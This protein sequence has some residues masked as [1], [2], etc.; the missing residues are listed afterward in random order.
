MDGGQVQATRA[1]EIS[2]SVSPRERRTAQPPHFFFFFVFDPPDR[3]PFH[4][5]PIEK[6]HHHRPT[7]LKQTNKAFKSKHASKGLLKD[8]SKGKVNRVAPKNQVPKGRTTKADR[9]NAAKLL[10]QKKREELV[11]S[12]RLFEGRHGAPKIVAVV[13]LCPDVDAEAAISHLYS[14]IGEDL[15]TRAGLSVL[16]ADR[17]KQKIQFVPLRRNFIDVIDAFKVAD[18]AILLMSA[19]VEVDK[20][21]LLCLSAIQHQGLVSVVPVVQHLEKVT[22]KLRPSVRKSLVSFTKQFFPEEDKLLAIDNEADAVNILRHISEQRP[23]PLAWRDQ[24]PY[25]VAESVTF[26]PNDATEGSTGTLEVTGYARGLPF[27]AN[28]LVHLQN[29]GDFQV[30]QV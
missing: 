7:G 1:R 17:F 23:K 22:Q 9:R 4:T 28:R 27:N 2:F 8:R 18:F 29:F 14:S 10:Q 3:E 20:F 25:L 19:E 30:K 13:P 5:M 11:R 26:R 24:H 6:S 21:G 15:P 16:D 12:N